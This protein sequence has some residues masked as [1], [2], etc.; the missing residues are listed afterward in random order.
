MKKHISKIVVIIS[1]TTTSIFTLGFVDS[2]F[3]VSKNL[4]IFA[5]L[6]RELN[7]YYVD[8]AN[9]GD[10]MKTG[11]DAMLKSLDP[12]TNYIPESK[13]EDYKMMTTG[14]YGGIGALIQKQGEY[15]IVSEPYQGFG[16]FKAGLRAGDKILEIDGNSAKNKNSSEIREF[17]LGEPGTTV[18]IKIERPGTA[19]TILKTVTREKVKIKDVPYSA[20]VSDTVGY[21]KLTGFTET[22]SAEVKNALKELTAQ[23]AKSFIL[24]LRGNGGGLLREAVNIVNL[25][26]NQGTEVVFTKGKV[27]D[28]DKNYKALSAP[29]STTV[30][31]V[32]LV[33]GGSASA[34]EIVS[35]SLQ[36]NDRAVIIGSQ[37]FGK[38]LVQQVRPLSYN[39]KLKVTVA[40]YYTPSG[41]CIQKL[42]Y[43]H[44][45]TDGKA[46]EVPDSLITEFKTLISKRSVF[47]GNGIAPDIKAS[48]DYLNDITSILVV[49]NLIFNY[50][51]QYRLKHDSIA[52]SKSFTLSDAEYED[53]VA[54]LKDK[55]YD[56]TTESE[57]LLKELEETAKKDKYY[58]GIKKEY[59]ALKEK[60]GVHKKDDLH[61]FKSEIK[62]VLEN[63]I[64]ARYYFQVGQME[65]AL[66]NDPAFDVALKTIN[67]KKTYSSILDGSYKKQ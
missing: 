47:D 46:E 7:I 39:S 41:R 26:V 28:W 31:L 13:M 11:I 8:E 50:A 19:E 48:R 62:F 3:E 4:D 2:Y 6:F 12:Y 5:T 56:Y 23:N 38:G 21:I 51:T 58:D 15:V 40:K 20:M 63:E 43:S 67:D 1:I 60:L 32:I 9:P 36:D 10:L 65:A 25:F 14:Q 17:L 45:N 49:K 24:D 44:K 55:D 54:Y 53:F 30:P 37:S 64:I 59:S 29:F 61:Q 35:G 27:K 33:D 52:D 22:A 34:S 18:T 16:A 42:D 57:S 66:K